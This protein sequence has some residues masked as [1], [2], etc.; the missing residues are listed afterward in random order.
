MC[1]LQRLMVSHTDD[2]G[3]EKRSLYLDGTTPHPFLS[4]LTARRAL[5]LAIDR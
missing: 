2:L 3:P 4:E 1:R 5:S